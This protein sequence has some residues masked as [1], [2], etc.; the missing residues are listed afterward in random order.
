MRS[1]HNI[2][3]H[4]R[5][6][7]VHQPAAESQLYE[8]RADESAKSYE[9]RGATVIEGNGTWNRKAETGNDR[10]YI[11]VQQYGRSRLHGTQ[12]GLMSVSVL[13][14]RGKE[15]GRENSKSSPKHLAQK[16]ELVHKKNYTLIP[17]ECIFTTNQ[18]SSTV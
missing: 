3:R 14:E 4:T 9:A 15:G 8:P 5:A 12:C 13:L 1:C 6:P 16:L 2:T 10:Q 17:S 11:P 18:C 7:R